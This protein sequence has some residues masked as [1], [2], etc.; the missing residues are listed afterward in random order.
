MAVLVPDVACC[1]LIW[2]LQKMKLVVT[3]YLFF[4]DKCC[5]LIMTLHLMEPSFCA[6]KPDESGWFIPGHRRVLPLWQLRPRGQE[7]A[8]SC[9]RCWRRAP[10]SKTSWERN[11]GGKQKT[12][13]ILF[14]KYFVT[15]PRFWSRL[16]LGR[17]LVRLR[18]SFFR[19]TF[20]PRKSALLHL[21]KGP[22]KGKKRNLQ[23]KN[24]DWSQS[25]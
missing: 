10:G 12:T 15:K 4:W 16:A 14:V 2:P 21:Q 6:K 11:Q 7:V 5:P 25:C 20:T 13:D 22:V 18:M 19:S 17:W 3:T 8:Q 23:V 9:L 24:P 1:V